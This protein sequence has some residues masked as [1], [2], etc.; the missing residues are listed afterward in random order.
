MKKYIYIA[1]LA[2]ASAALASCSKDGEAQEQFMTIC[3]DYGMTVDGVQVVSIG[4]YRVQTSFYEDKKQFRVSDDTME[5][6]Y[7]L[8]VD[9]IPSGEGSTFEGDLGW[10]NART[11]S[12]KSGLSFKVISVEDDRFW[13]WCRM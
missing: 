13:V 1:I 3:S 12:Q 5:N 11:A 2:A 10:G 7:V 9:K 6:F 8:T 4:E